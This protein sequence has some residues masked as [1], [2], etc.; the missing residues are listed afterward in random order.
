MKR[1]M[2]VI[3]RIIRLVIAIV[4]ISLFASGILAGTIGTILLIIAIVF[5][6]TSV[7]GF[8]PM[9]TIFRIKSKKEIV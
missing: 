5:A 4:L 7:V 3:D 9:Y 1:N 2:G 8:C 6:L